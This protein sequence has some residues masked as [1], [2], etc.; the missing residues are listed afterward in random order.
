MKIKLRSLDAGSAPPLVLGVR[1]F[2]QEL[3]IFFFFF[4][5]CVIVFI[6]VIY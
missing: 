4:F 3:G 5:F 1:G 2:G 6:V